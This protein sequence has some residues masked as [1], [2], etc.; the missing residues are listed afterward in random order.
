MG[1]HSRQA[2]TVKEG[3]EGRP[4]ALGQSPHWDGWSPRESSDHCLLLACVWLDPRFV[5]CGQAWS[6]LEI[7]RGTSPSEAVS[8]RGQ[9]SK[10]TNDALLLC[11]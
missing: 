2:E 10:T 5:T 6:L 8:N 1:G 7:S 3:A 9:T 4:G 11:D